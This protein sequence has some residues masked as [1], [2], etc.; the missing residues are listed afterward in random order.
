MGGGGAEK[1]GFA[2]VLECVCLVLSV[3]WMSISLRA[4]VQGVVETPGGGSKVIWGGG[5]SW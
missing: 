1:S 2:M 5:L 3:F 4:W